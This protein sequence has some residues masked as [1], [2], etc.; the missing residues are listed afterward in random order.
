MHGR[1]FWHRGLFRVLVVVPISLRGPLIEVECCWCSKESYVILPMEH[2]IELP[3]TSPRMPISSDVY[4]ATAHLAMGMARRDRW[5]G[6]NMIVYFDRETPNQ[7]DLGLFCFFQGIFGRSLF[8][9]T[10]M[11]VGRFA[12][13]ST[14]SLR[15][16]HRCPHPSAFL[17]SCALGVSHKQFPTESEDTKPKQL[18]NMTGCTITLWVFP[19]A[20]ITATVGELV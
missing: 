6:L 2:Q 13:K 20:L 3:R 5:A 19:Y 7:W 17:Q 1:S 11:I 10:H 14:R 9:Y 4:K 15:S 8:I 18:V 16:S 12:K